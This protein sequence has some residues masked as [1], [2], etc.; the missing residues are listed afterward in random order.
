M[1]K[2]SGQKLKLLYLM[3]I[4]NE[5]TDE[6]HPLT[7]PELIAELE[8]YGIAA[9]RK[10]LYADLELLMQFGMDLCR[11]N[12]RPP[13]YYVGARTFEM[14]ELEMLID[15]VQASKFITEKKTLSLIGKLQSLCSVHQARGLTRQVYVKN[16]IKSMNETIYLNIDL[17]HA[18]ITQNRQIHFYYFEYDREKNRVYRHSGKRYQISPYALIWD[19]ENY[20]LI[21]YDPESKIIKHYRVDKMAQIQ[22]GTEERTGGEVF[23]QIDISGYTK[24]NFSMFGG[25]EEIV[26]LRF[27]NH[28]TGVVLDRFGKDT[29][30]TKDRES[31]FRVSIPIAVSPQFFGFLF[32]LGTD[33]EILSPAHVRA[34]MPTLLRQISELYE[35]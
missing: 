21:A 5:L 18:A 33:A 28:L 26:T 35:S 9:E 24:R 16:R 3:R 22:I 31:H 7:M 4:F 13:G 8:R 14:P 34:Q 1:A 6:D 25:K 11:T 23:A 10:T 29:I 17:L 30:L 27:S 32:S 2:N 20:Y 19:N 12:N 15:S